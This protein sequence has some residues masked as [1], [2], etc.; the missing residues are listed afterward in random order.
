MKNIVSNIKVLTIRRILIGFSKSSN[1]KAINFNFK[2]LAKYCSRDSGKLM[3][4]S[5]AIRTSLATLFMM[6]SKVLISKV[7]SR[8][9]KM[10]SNSQLVTVELAV[11]RK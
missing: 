2:T 4:L 1:Q 7:N 8:Q 6:V 11:Y 5:Q 9:R 3:M 10:G